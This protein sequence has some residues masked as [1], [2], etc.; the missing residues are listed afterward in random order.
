MK[1][2]LYFSRKNIYVS[3]VLSILVLYIHANNLN[4]YTENILLARTIEDFIGGRIGDIVVPTFFMISGFL[5]YRNI[6]IQVDCTKHIKSKLKKRFHSLLIPYLFW[7]I[8]GTIFYM[9]APRIPKIGTMISGGAASITLSNIIEGVFYFKY[10]FPLWYLFYLIVMVCMAPILVWL[11]KNKKVSVLLLGTLMLGYLMEFKLPVLSCGSIFFYFLGAYIAIYNKTFWTRKERK[12]RS[13][14]CL[15]VL[16]LMTIFRFFY[17]ENIVGRLFYLA[18][19]IFLWKSFD[20]LSYKT[21]PSKFVGQSFF[22]YC[23]HI[24]PLTTINKIFVKVSNKLPLDIGATVS[25]IMTP[26]CTIALLFV[27]HEFLTK[28]CPK[29]YALISGGRT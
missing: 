22:I 26:M 24:I 2:E 19:P 14:I 6:D 10:Y 15:C 1:P 20:V 3:F 21:K 7:N 9:F 23:A 12:S 17:V 18:S 28:R 8:V 29:F 4:Y 16:L 5:F 13:W 11:L 25:Y 27:V